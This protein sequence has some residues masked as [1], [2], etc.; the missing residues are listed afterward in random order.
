MQKSMR[1]HQQPHQ[2]ETRN[3]QQKYTHAHPGS[4]QHDFYTLKQRTAI[5]EHL[6]DRQQPVCE[7]CQEAEVLSEPHTHATTSV[8]CKSRVVS[9]CSNL[10]C[11]ACHCLVAAQNPKPCKAAYTTSYPTPSA[12]DSCAVQEMSAAMAAVACRVRQCH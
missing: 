7:M 12:A 5:T 2:L 10:M 8:C 3:Q 4:P 9:T 6:L 1:R 11:H